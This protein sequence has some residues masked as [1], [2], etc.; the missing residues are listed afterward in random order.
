MRTLSLL[1]FLLLPVSLPAQQFVHAHPVFY[2]VI[3]IKE[4]QRNVLASGD[5]LLREG[6]TERVTAAAGQSRVGLQITVRRSDNASPRLEVES[7]IEVAESRG[8][9]RVEVADK[10]DSFIQGPQVNRVR[11][12]DRTWMPMR[13]PTPLEVI[14]DSEDG[15][16]VFTLMFEPQPR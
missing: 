4:G 5:M 8:S 2:E 13:D 12:S 16:Y 9:Q 3:S 11:F 6:H 15:R 14:H 10:P 1:L 7:Q